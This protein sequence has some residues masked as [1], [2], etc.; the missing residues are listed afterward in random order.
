MHATQWKM[1]SMHAGYVVR[2]ASNRHTLLAHPQREVLAQ[3]I[4]MK[5]A[6][7]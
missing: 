2:E 3:H 1:I 6:I 5:C 4:D 7:S